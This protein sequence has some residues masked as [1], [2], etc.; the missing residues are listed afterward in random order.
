[1]WLDRAVRAADFVFV[2]REVQGRKKSRKV[3]WD[4]LA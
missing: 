2:G 4:S 3:D 1:M